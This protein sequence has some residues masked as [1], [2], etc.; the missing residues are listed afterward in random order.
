MKKLSKRI[1]SRRYTVVSLQKTAVLLIGL[2]L[3]LSTVYYLLSTAPR[4]QAQEIQRTYTVINPSIF[5]ELNPGEK[6]EGTTK[7]INESNVPLTFEIS[8]QDY[9]VSDTKGT[10]NLLPPNTLSS[11]YSGA[12][13]I[14]VTP[15]IFTLNPRQKQTINY[16]IQV[17][18]DGSAGGH[19]AAIVYSPANKDA[20]AQTGGVVNTQIGSIFYLTVKGPIKESASVSKFITD[21]FQEYGP[22]KILTQIKNM[23]DLHISPKGTVTVTGLFFNEKQELS[24]YNIFPET[25]RDFEN[26]FGKN[27]MIGRYKASLIASYGQNNNLPLTAVFYFWVFPWRLA[28][29]IILIIVAVILGI[30]YWRKKKDTQKKTEPNTEGTRNNQDN[31]EVIK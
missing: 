23:G 3:L 30:M 8:V 12:A 7:V 14:G 2:F 17:P 15:S 11:K 18:P 10:P 6:A 25:A 19:Y 26:T 31:Q 5:H 16:Y 29:V 9:I 4:A 20:G 28:I 13:W 22:V 1:K 21:V 24:K 27:F